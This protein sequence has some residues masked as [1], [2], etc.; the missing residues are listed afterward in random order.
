MA[1]PLHLKI[2]L[3]SPGDVADERQ[4]IVRLIKD[5]L[6]YDELIRGQATFDVLAWDD[7][8]Q[9]VA[10]L[11]GLSGQASVEQALGTPSE[12][13]LTVVV[14]RT[15]LGTPPDDR[16][17]KADGTPYRSGTEWELWNA[18][19]AQKPV[20]ICRGPGERTLDLGKLDELEKY[21]AQARLVEE[22]FEDL[23][24]RKIFV[25]PYRETSELVALVEGEL[26]RIVR[27]RLEAM[28]SI[29]PVATAAIT[30]TRRARNNLPPTTPTSSAARRC[31]P[32]CAACSLV[33]LAPPFR[34]RRS[35]AWAA[36]ARPRPRWPTATATL[37][38]IHSSGG[39]AP[40]A[41]RCS[42]PT[43]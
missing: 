12:C 32:S 27:R 37:P 33:A 28:P 26:K 18:L 23:A 14:V 42:P 21:L 35:P 20:M 31:S 24:A 22:F 11:A 34:Y 7:R 25:N 13:D 30:A 17:L 6:P 8:A 16:P 40:R 4:A 43:S 5:E 10:L 2:F 39:F 29:A 38:T 1:G 41:P 36:S 15:H 3:S 19:E 9:R